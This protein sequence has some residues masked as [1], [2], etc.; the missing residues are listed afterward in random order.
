MLHSEVL[1]VGHIVPADGATERE[2]GAVWR[3]LDLERASL[4]AAAFGQVCDFI[5]TDV[6]AIALPLVARLAEVSVSPAEPLRDRAAEFAFELDKI[7]SVILALAC[8]QAELR[9]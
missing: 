7:C 2:F 5:S 8:A 6:V 4:F 3:V 9:C 1:H